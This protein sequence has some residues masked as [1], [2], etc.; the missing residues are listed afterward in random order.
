MHGL[1]YKDSTA[2]LASFSR[3]DL[4]DKASIDAAVAKIG[5]KVDG[6]FNCAG[7]PQ[8]APV[9]D[10]D[11]SELYRAPPFDGT[12]APADAFGQCDRQ[13]RVDGRHGMVAAHTDRDGFHREP[14]LRGGG[15]VVRRQQGYGRRGLFLLEGSRW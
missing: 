3:M 13:Y 15:Q 7:L 4:R 11:E 9:M 12:R 5:G 8:T 2:K 10:N 6:L 1:D 14:R